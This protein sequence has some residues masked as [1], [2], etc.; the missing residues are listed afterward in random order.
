MNEPSLQE[1]LIH[2]ALRMNEAGINHGKSGNV[3]VRA[4]L[5]GMDGFWI[6]P[7]GLPYERT[8]PSDLV[9]MA[10][11]DGS[12]RG[13]SAYAPS[14]EWRFHLDIYRAR[15]DAHAIVHCHSSFATTLACVG[16]AIPAFHYMI[17]AAGGKDIRCAPYATFGTQEL[18]DHVVTAL[19]ERKA[20][21]MAQHGQVAIGTSLERALALAVE[22]EAL[23]K[24]YWQALQIGEPPILADDEMQRVI[25]RFATYGE[26]LR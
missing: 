10:V 21:L 19:V 15:S 4:Q 9:F 11:A 20:C 14:S 1:R 7:S 25:A 24:M 23:S 5:D 2:T 8:N 13:N 18:S 3:S 6:T 16:K 22:V 12:V 17:A 26:R